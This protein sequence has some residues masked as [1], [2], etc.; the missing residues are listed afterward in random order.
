MMFDPVT[1]LIS[2]QSAQRA[3]QARRPQE[4]RTRASEKGARAGDEDSFES[5]L[6]E[7]EPIGPT[8][9]L[10]DADQEE[11]RED[12]T[13]HQRRTGQTRGSLDITA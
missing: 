10:A 13:E 7:V 11:A 8:R 3:A 2:N 6:S 5:I 9:P 12:R 1:N 4:A